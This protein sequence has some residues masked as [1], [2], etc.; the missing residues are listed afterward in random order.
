MRAAD[1]LALIILSLVLFAVV[2]GGA[3]QRVRQ[4]DFLNDRQKIPDSELF[5]EADYTESGVGL[6]F[7]IDKRLSYFSGQYEEAVTRFEGAVSSYRYKAEI[8]VFLARSYYY[9]KDPDLARLTIERAVAIMP[10]LVQNLWDPLLA[11]LLG[12][13]R[14]G[15][16]NLQ[17]QV[18]FYSK[19][20]GD[21]L[22][23]FR[24]Y[25]FFKDANAS[26]KLSVNC[27]T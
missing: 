16:L 4:M 26:F 8:W 1:Q 19:T 24:L 25:L 9:Q 10:D 15:A 11:S 27:S 20:P 21:F 2:Q 22:T 3:Q 13:I 17:V 12:E 14:K 5:S 6:R 18:D 7:G 23:L